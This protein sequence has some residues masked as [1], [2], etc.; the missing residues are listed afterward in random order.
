MNRLLLVSLFVL[1]G[2]PELFGQGSAGYFNAR[3][4]MTSAVDAKG[5]RH[6][7][8]TYK[9]GAPWLGDR[10]SGPAPDYPMRERAMHHVGRCI[11]RLTL[12]LKT[13]H[14][15]KT[16]LLKSCGHPV[17]D[18]CALVAFSHWTWRPGR[19]KEV[20]LPTTFELANPSKPPVPGATRLP[21]S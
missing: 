1:C 9:S 15:I 10:V 6:D 18:R 5:V 12:D 4:Y 2:T 7:G 17:L 19:W 3:S 11:V 8:R 16:S 14:V 20:D 21:R 13:G